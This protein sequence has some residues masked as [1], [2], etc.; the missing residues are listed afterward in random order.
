MMKEGDN[1]LDHTEFCIR[2]VE[3]GYVLREHNIVDE[4]LNEDPEY[5]IFVGTHNDLNLYIIWY[6]EQNPGLTLVNVDAFVPIV[7]RAETLDKS[8]D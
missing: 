3:M 7:R 6:G 1:P 2:S 5:I 8:G 4:T